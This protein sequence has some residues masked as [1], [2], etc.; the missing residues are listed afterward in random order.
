MSDATPIEGT[1]DR[2]WLILGVIGIAQLMVIADRKKE[3]AFSL[4]GMGSATTN[5]YN[6][7][8]SRQG[9]AEVATR[10]SELGLAGRRDAAASLVTDEMLLATTLIGTEPM[11]RQRLRAT[12]A[13]AIE[14]V[15]ETRPITAAGLARRVVVLLAGPRCRG[16][17]C[18]QVELVAF[19]VGEGGPPDL[20]PLELPD[21][22]SAEAGKALALPLEPIG[23]QVQVQ[24]ILDRLGLWDLLEGKPGT[25]SGISGVDR[26]VLGVRTSVDRAAECLGPEPRQG[27]GIGAVNA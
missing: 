3:L 10:I 6:Q 7:A 14:L 12:L 19:G 9:W 5:F 16:R 2:R 22:H 13:R 8:Y 17:G 25:A 1:R 23:A 24:A 18:Y 26:G 11:I 4:G 21:G 20:R 15:R 27:S